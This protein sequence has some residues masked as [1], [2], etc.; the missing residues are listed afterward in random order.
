MTGARRPVLPV[1]AAAIATSTLL[2]GITTMTS[3]SGDVVGVWTA[4]QPSGVWRT[5]DASGQIR[6]ADLDTMP[7]PI[8]DRA[9]VTREQARSIADS[10]DFGD[11]TPGEPR[12]SLRWA[13]RPLAP[14]QPDGFHHRLAWIVEYAH[15]PAMV[16]GPPDLAPTDRAAIEAHAVCDFVIAIDAHTGEILASLQSCR[17]PPGTDARR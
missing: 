17:P 9:G 12:I 5:P 14:H 11:L 7:A 8:N 13:T 4:P 15:S 10:L 1:A 6:Y 2:L 3:A 16:L